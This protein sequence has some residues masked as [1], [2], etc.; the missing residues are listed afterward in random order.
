MSHPHE[1]GLTRT[2]RWVTTTSLGGLAAAQAVVGTW[3]LT[4]PGHFY[5]AFPAAGH[6]WVALL[7]PYNEHLVRDVGALSLAVGVLLGAAAVMPSRLLVAIAV[8][9]FTTYALPHSAF[10]ALH[11][12]R[13]PDT[14]AVAQMAGFAVQLAAAAAALAGIL[15]LRRPDGAAPSPVQARH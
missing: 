15:V 2:G 9:T 14:D 6:A 10:H 1:P 12:D 8:T 5:R 4:A 7:P 3:A 11:L 13:F